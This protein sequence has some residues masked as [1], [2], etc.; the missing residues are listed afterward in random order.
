MHL[1]HAAGPTESLQVQTG[2]FFSL[3]FIFFPL[4]LFLLEVDIYLIIYHR[5]QG[6]FIT[7]RCSQNESQRQRSTSGLLHSSKRRS[8]LYNTMLVKSRLPTI[9]GMTPH[10]TSKSLVILEILR[11]TKKYLKQ[12]KKGRKK[13]KEEEVIVSQPFVKHQYHH[14]S[15]CKNQRVLVTCFNKS[16]L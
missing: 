10:E 13:S 14:I 2:M 12:I 5:C 1:K 7:A 6:C 15:T 9:Q 11:K 3:A 4:F 16:T 8:E